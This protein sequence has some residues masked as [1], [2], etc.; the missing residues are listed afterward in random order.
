MEIRSLGTEPMWTPTVEGQAGT[1]STDERKFQ[2]VRRQIQIDKKKF[3]RKIQKSCI[4]MYLKNCHQKYI[5]QKLTKLKVVVYKSKII[6]AH[7][8]VLLSV[9]L[10]QARK[11]SVSMQKY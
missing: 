10:E 6:V 3:T 1:T 4:Y 9:V 8:N 11:K 2:R 7:F 5:K